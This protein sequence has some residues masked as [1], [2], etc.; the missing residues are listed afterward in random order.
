MDHSI[1]LLRKRFANSRELRAFSTQGGFAQLVGRSEGYIRNVEK[2]VVPLSSKLAEV[3]EDKTGVSAKWLLRSGSSD[4]IL[5]PDGSAWEPGVAIQ[6]IKAEIDTN[7]QALTQAIAEATRRGTPVADLVS[8]WVKNAVEVD[9]EKG[10]LD[11]LAAIANLLRDS[12]HLQ[13]GSGHER[14]P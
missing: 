5:R 14:M 9:L 3:V 7:K 10:S 6:L 12:G 13:I 2:G 11:L 4:P 8:E 1:K